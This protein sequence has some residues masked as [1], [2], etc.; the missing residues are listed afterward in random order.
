MARGKRKRGIGIVAEAEIIKGAADEAAVAAVKRQFPD[1]DTSIEC[2]RWYRSRLKRAGYGVPTS[3]EAKQPGR[4]Q[5]IGPRQ[6][7]AT[8]PASVTTPR[9]DEDRPIHP[10][11]RRK[12]SEKGDRYGSR[13]TREEMGAAVEAYLE[14]LKLQDAG[15]NF[16]QL[17]F[18]QRLLDGAL[19]GRSS[20]SVQF[21]FCNISSV[22]QDHSHRRLECFA[23]LEGVGANQRKVLVDLLT[24]RGVSLRAERTTGGTR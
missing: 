4:D 16:R 2:I 12:P 22:L 11:F 7:G 17:D 21:R 3:A 5:G 9:K 8:G 19:S 10:A 20:K 24:E 18:T 23:P 15:V 6:N 1:A 13:W 14:M